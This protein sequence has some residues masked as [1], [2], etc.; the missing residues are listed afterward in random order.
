MPETDAVMRVAGLRVE[1]HARD[2]IVEDVAFEVRRGEVLAL[3]GESGSGKTTTALA[4]M[5]HARAG[6]RIA[7][8]SVKLGEFEVLTSRTRLRDVRG[9]QIAYVPQDPAGALDPRQ[10]IGP[11]MAEVMTAHAVEC[12]RAQGRVRELLESVGLP[13]T[14][15]F[16]RRWPWRATHS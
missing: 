11:Q 8:G 3:V 7:G 16:L 12:R 13:S 2:A 1:T 10:R 4:L 5:G 6:A 15:E 14:R 9:E